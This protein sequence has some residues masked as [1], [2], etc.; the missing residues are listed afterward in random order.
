MKI[1]TVVGAR[2]HFVKAA[3]V[4][5]ALIAAKLDEVL[6]HTGQHYDSAM[7]D[8][9]FGELNLPEPAYHLEI[10]SAGHGEQTGRMLA[11]IEPVLEKEKPDIVLVYGDTNSTLAGALAAAKLNMPVAHVEAGV[12]SFNRQMPEETNRIVVDAVSSYLFAPNDE[13]VKNLRSAEVDATRVHLVGDVMYDSTLLFGSRARQS[14]DASERLKLKPKGYVLATIHRAESTND[15]AT[16]SSIFG[17][18]TELSRDVPVILPLHPRTAAVVDPVSKA[19]LLKA[20]GVIIDPVGYLDMLRLEQDAAIVVTDSGGVQKEAFW[21]EVP[22]ITLRTE[23]EW[24]EL[25]DAG[26]NTLLPPSE[27]GSLR[28]L[29]RQRIGKRGNPV[30]PYGDGH[31]AEKIATILTG[32]AN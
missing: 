25:V 11:A 14:S 1:V 18:L 3:P 22:C 20:G 30:Q 32:V 2:P 10:G 12:R 4:S 26:W 6:V 17:A 19:A 9:F 29:A 21:Q 31:A 27:V 23:T 13:A 24:T 15:K 7:S 28:E 16:L 5:R 8:I